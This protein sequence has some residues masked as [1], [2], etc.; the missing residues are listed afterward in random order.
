MLGKLVCTRIRRS[1][2][3]FRPTSI[4]EKDLTK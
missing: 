4:L 2:D 3:V 1:D